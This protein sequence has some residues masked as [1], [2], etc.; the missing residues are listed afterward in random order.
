MNLQK[1]YTRFIGVVFVLV[2][3]S[4][5]LDFSEFGFREETW[6]KIFHVLLGFIVI[7]YG[8]NNERFWKPFCISNGLFFT[9]VALFGWMYMDFGGLD[10]F[11]FVDTVLHSAVGLSGLLIG[12]FYKKN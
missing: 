11:N 8:W 9:F 7:Y 3:I 5:I 10:A 12:F 6:H 2:F 1:L 4:L